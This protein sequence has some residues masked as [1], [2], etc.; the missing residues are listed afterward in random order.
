MTRIGTFLIGALLA[1]AAAPA[2]AAPDGAQSFAAFVKVCGATHV[3]YPAVQAAADANGWKP[4]QVKSDAFPGATVTESLSRDSSVGG[5]ALTLYAWRGAKGAFQMS[6]CTV[7]VGKGQF[8][9][10]QG[11]AQSWLGFAPQS[12]TAKKATFLFTDQ[13]DTHKALASADQDAAAAGTGMQIL[14]VGGD[15][16]GAILGILKI[17]K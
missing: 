5:S 10:M 2:L 13:G 4:T 3:D 9:E 14:T 11:L 8:A 7:R 12:A 6:E 15:D 16:D 17:K 1:G